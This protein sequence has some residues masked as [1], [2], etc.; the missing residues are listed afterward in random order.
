MKHGERN[1]SKF[2]VP[3]V[4]CGIC[5][6]FSHKL[7]NNDTHH[8]DWWWTMYKHRHSWVIGYEDFRKFKQNKVSTSYLRSISNAG[9]RSKTNFFSSNRNWKL[10]HM[11][12]YA[13]IAMGLFCSFSHMRFGILGKYICAAMNK[14]DINIID[15]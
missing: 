3:M 15:V 12:K 2:R 1:R 5:V 6:K 13:S 14:I 10:C 4:S 8:Q 11:V 7:H 9:E